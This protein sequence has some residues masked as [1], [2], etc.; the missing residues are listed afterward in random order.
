M[1]VLVLLTRSSLVAFCIVSAR[2][3]PSTDVFGHYGIE[4]L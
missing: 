3:L 2:G 1:A 4:P